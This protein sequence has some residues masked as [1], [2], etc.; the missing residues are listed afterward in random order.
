MC[1]TAGTI[2]SEIDDAGTVRVRYLRDTEGKALAMDQAGS[3]YFFLYNEHGGV[4]KVANSSG[5]TVASYAYDEFGDLI[6]ST[7]TLYNLLRYSGGNNGYYDAETGL[8]KMGARD[9]KSETGRWITRDAYSG[10]PQEPQS[11]HRYG[12]CESNATNKADTT[13]YWG[14]DLHRRRTEALARAV[15]WPRC[16]VA[17]LG[18]GTEAVDSGSNTWQTHLHFD[19]I[20][21]RGLA[22]DSR[23]RHYGR[24]YRAALRCAR[25]GNPRRASFAL[26][27]G[28]HAWPQ[29]YYAHGHIRRREH[30]YRYG[31]LP[32]LEW[33]K[34]DRRYRGRYGRGWP[35]YP[36]RA[37]RTW[38]DTRRQLRRFLRQAPKPL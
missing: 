34:G 17:Q 38:A 15:R 18:R 20:L 27:Y 22:Y 1:D 23:Y 11:Q 19:T 37:T 16:Y 24:Q 8:Y 28:P 21:R 4:V 33:W 9:Y 7:G 35:G 30:I 31:P 3:L 29:D 12:Y 32:D 13:G 6:S 14:S 26:G 2:L 36:H 5:Q 10:E 25:R